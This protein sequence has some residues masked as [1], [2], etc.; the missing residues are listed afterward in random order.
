[1][2]PFGVK[3]EVSKRQEKNVLLLY[4]DYAAILY[5]FYVKKWAK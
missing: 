3:I 1:M 2:A 5:L 4:M